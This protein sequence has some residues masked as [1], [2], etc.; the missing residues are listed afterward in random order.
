MKTNQRAHFTNRSHP[1]WKLIRK[2]KAKAHLVSTNISQNQNHVE[3][4]M[5]VDV[6]TELFQHLGQ[7]A[8]STG[9]IPLP[10]FQGDFSLIRTNSDYCCDDYFLLFI[11][12]ADLR[13]L[14]HT[15][16]LGLFL[17]GND[18][19]LDF[20]PTTWLLGHEESQ[21]Q[22]KFWH[23]GRPFQWSSHYQSSTEAA[24]ALRAQWSPC[25]VFAGALSST[26]HWSPHDPIHRLWLTGWPSSGEGNLWISHC[27]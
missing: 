1:D 6:Y 25:L 17:V 2:G 13:W 9:E 16:F 15:K 5:D 20:S 12:P 26:L 10:G 22:I 18:R 21:L 27:P 8:D 24:E 7:R 4:L 23:S 11:V 14:Y 3:S 19:S